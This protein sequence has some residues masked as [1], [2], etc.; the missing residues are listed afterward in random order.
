MDFPSID[1]VHEMLEDI[2]EDIPETFF[3]GLNGG[4]ILEEELKFHSESRDERPLY[5]MGEYRQS[6]LGKS[7]AIYYGS[8]KRAYKYEYEFVI[9]EKIKE[10]LIHEFTHHLE[11]MA[12]NIDL[13]IEDEEIL[14]DYRKQYG[15]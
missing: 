6:V 12:G 14:K 11:T 9:Y 1:E 4:I 10:V 13:R 3:N 2:L 8:L 5:I 7:I 15:D